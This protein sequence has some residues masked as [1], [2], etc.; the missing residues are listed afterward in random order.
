[1]HEKDRE[2]EYETGRRTYIKPRS[3]R[4]EK[5]GRSTVGWMTLYPSALSGQRWMKRTSSTLRSEERLNARLR[6]TENQR[7]H[8]VG[9]LVGVHHFQVDQMP[10]DTKLV[11]DA[12]AA[13]HVTGRAGDIQRLA[14]AVALHDGGDFHRRRALVL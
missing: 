3:E 11:A 12:V 9:A 2:H 6:T 14:A 1:G 10:G 4:D 7:V 8:I 13:Q 5:T